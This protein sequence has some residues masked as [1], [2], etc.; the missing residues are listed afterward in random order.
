MLSTELGRGDSDNEH[1]EGKGIY[2]VDGVVGDY[3]RPL[4]QDDGI[5]YTLRNKEK[6]LY[7]R[8]LSL[9]MTSTC[10]ILNGNTT[11]QI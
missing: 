2:K 9:W 6:S 4:S 10:Q 8:S 11:Q 7:Q 1:G 5:N 3:Y